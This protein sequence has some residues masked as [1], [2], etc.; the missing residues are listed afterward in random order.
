MVGSS[1]RGCAQCIRPGAIL[2]VGKVDRRKT[3]FEERDVDP[4]DGLHWPHSIQPAFHRF[5]RVAVDMLVRLTYSTFNLYSAA[6]ISNCRCGCMSAQLL[7]SLFLGRPSRVDGGGMVCSQLLVAWI[8]AGDLSRF[9]C[10]NIYANHRAADFPAPM[11]MDG[12]HL[13]AISPRPSRRSASD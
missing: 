6:I 13:A 11:P 4:T 9:L 7:R 2:T 1:R 3:S 10:R 8:A 5:Y 12:I